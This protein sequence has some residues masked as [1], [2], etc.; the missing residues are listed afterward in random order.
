MAKRRRRGRGEGS[1]EELPDGRW[2]AVLSLGTGPDG[3][4]VRRKF[5]GKTKAEALG[6]LREAQA[7]HAG[8]TLTAPTRLTVG[9]W[10]QQWLAFREGKI[11]PKTW[12]RYE[13]SVRCH[14]TPQLGHLALAKLTALHVEGLYAALAKAGLSPGEQKKAGG[15]LSTALR[16]A[17]RL[18]LVS[19][20]VAA[21]VPRPKAARRQFLA[22]D[23]GQARRFLDAARTDRLY[24]LHALRLDAGLRPGEAFA[25]TWPDVD[26]AAGTISITKSLESLND[27]LRVKD[28]KTKG[29][30]RTLPLSAATVQAL[31]AH[32]QKMAAEK[33]DT[34][35]GLVFCDSHGGHLRH[36][37]VNNRSYLPAV[38]RAGVPRIPYY[39]LR[40]C[41]ATLLLTNGVNVKVVSERLGHASIQITLDYY[42]HVMPG[43][44][45][46]AAETMGKILST[47]SRGQLPGNC[48]P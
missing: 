10:L 28:L 4:R 41:C 11:E 12:A 13:V 43:M 23:A 46:A 8:G 38:R 18:C 47:D 19:R 25:L 44:Q 3:K 21:E 34:Q 14:L 35:R 1:V 9:E 37:N 6:K 2:R 40:H 24:A 31:T 5:Y 30:R 36:A 7:A 22:W 15:C 39:D 45:K 29:S 20:N 32:R 17:A 26:L 33:K 48:Q 42:A 27:Q 16:H